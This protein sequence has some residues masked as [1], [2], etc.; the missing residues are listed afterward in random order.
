MKFVQIGTRLINLAQI[1]FVSLNNPHGDN[2]D[3][4]TIYF[5][6]STPEG[7]LS[8]YFR[9]D[10]AQEARRILAAAILEQGAA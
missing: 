1:A 6:A 10:E 9:D 5:A 8:V 3:G 7:E 4:V 2:R